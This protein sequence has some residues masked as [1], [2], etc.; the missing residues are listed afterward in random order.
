[1]FDTT[2]SML[3][4]IWCQS[5]HTICMNIQWIIIHPPSV[6]FSTWCIIEHGVHTA[7]HSMSFFIFCAQST[8]CF[9]WTQFYQLKCYFAV[10]I[11]VH[12]VYNTID[13]N[14]THDS[15]R[16][17]FISSLQVYTFSLVQN[18]AT[19]WRYWH[20]HETSIMHSLVFAIPAKDISQISFY[21]S[22]LS[23]CWYKQFYF[24]QYSTRF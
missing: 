7:T 3:F 1:M 4:Y 17:T 18:M 6:L 22:H 14:N 21:Y 16:I 12:R 10:T 2:Q 19:R 15:I 8:F 20:I 5:M 9:L 11:S 24:I 13:Y 23:G